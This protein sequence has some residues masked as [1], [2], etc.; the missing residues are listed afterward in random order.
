MQN[1]ESVHEDLRMSE[2]GELYLAKLQLELTVKDLSEEV[3]I[4]SD[5]NYKLIQDLKT[6][7]FFDKYQ[8][9]LQEINQLKIE[10]EALIDYRFKEQRI[11]GS[12]LIYI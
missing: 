1:V 7:D 5:T 10:Q 2:K 11:T 12:M 4:L 3:E 9:V 8:N 6:R